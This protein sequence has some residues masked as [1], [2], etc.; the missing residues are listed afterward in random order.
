MAIL[1][2]KESVPVQGGSLHMCENINQAAQ[3]DT[4]P[5]LSMMD[6]SSEGVSSTIQ[7]V[8]TTETDRNFGLS[9]VL[10]GLELKAHCL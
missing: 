10:P 9:S 3:R 6:G 5:P 7:S 8:G 2:D 1:Y 4:A